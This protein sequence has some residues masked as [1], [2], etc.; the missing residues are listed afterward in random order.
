MNCDVNKGKRVVI[1]K[2]R[3]FTRTSLPSLLQND[4][5]RAVCMVQDGMTHDRP[6]VT[7]QL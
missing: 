1:L 5:E 6:R 7:S 4:R 3:I 2:I